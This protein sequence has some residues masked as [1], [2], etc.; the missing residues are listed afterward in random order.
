[1]RSGFY[2]RS[3]EIQ[4]SKIRNSD[5]VFL[6]TQS[7]IF[8]DFCRVRRNGAQNGKSPEPES[9][10]AAG[11]EPAAATGAAEATAAGTELPAAEPS[12]R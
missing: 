3:D 10:P 7:S 2:S 1:M 4:G 9:A 5:T 11:T 6:R 8:F 12:G